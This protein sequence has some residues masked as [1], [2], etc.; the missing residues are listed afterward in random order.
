[1]KKLFKTMTLFV[2]MALTACGGATTSNAD[3]SAPAGDSS[4][5]PQES[6]NTPSKSSTSKHTHT[7]D[8]TK[9]ES[10]DDYHWH[11][12]TCE[13]TDSKGSRAAHDWEEDT[14][15]AD[16]AT[17]E[18]AGKK[19]EKCKVCGK[20][21]VTDVDTLPHNWGE[22]TVNYPKETGYAQTSS[23]K[24]SYGDHYAL[25]WE[26]LDMDEALSL[27]ACGLQAK[28]TSIYAETNSDNIRLRKA[29]NDGG[30][31]A[32]G[33][34]VVYKVKVAT[35]VENAGLE[36]YAKSRS[37]YTIPVF[38]YVS[39]DSQ[40]GY[41]KK[42]DGTLELTTKRYGLRVNGAEV[43]L[44]ADKYGEVDGVTDWFDWNVKFNLQAGEN[45]IDVYC[46]GGYRANIYKFQIT[47]LAA[48]ALP[49][50]QA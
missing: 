22:P 30:N 13:H 1:M 46:L 29:E 34:H 9:W 20:E 33:T 24:C 35:A 19:Y 7:Y 16:A 43:K 12:A 45:I 4:G 5:A 49:S 36:F 25:R 40:Q 50:A 27:E 10:D 41:I 14:T 21:R 37:G 31:E 28:D 3:S 17:C 32:K 2:A 11:P 18:K 6:S 15:K 38:D 23:Y 48:T 44:G 39:N 8:E 47:G 42:D 26:A